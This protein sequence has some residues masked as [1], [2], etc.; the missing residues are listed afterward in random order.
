M[1]VLQFVLCF[2]LKQNLNYEP[3]GKPKLEYI[4]AEQISTKFLNYY[5]TISLIK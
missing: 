2:L 5:E 4:S 1:S 3:F